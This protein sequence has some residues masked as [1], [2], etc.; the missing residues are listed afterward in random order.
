M[1]TDLGELCVVLLAC[2]LQNLLTVIGY[3]CILW[4]TLLTVSVACTG[5]VFESGS[6]HTALNINLC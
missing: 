4:L 6:T 2:S 5:Y 1:D 3:V